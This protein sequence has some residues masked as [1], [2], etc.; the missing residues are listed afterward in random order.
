MADAV[1]DIISGDIEDTASLQ[2]TADDDVSMRMAGVV[3]IDRNP[4]EARLQVLFDLAHQVSREASQ[5]GHFIGVF[6][7]H[8]K[9]ELM[10]IFSTPLDERLAVSFVL[11]SRI[12]LP[13]LPVPIDPIAFKVAKVG[14]DRLVRRLRLRS[15][16]L[17]LLSLRIE[18]D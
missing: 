7:R 14:I 11:K 15:A 8:D 1:R 10:P 4:V 13:S 2:H 3:V 9:A 18:L 17:L 12:G 5:I 6:G 16:M